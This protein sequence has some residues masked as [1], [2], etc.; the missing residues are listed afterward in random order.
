MPTFL[1]SKEF[2]LAMAGV[3]LFTAGWVVNGWR[4]EA[5]RTKAVVQAGWTG[6]HL[7]GA[8]NQSSMNYQDRLREDHD[9]QIKRARI[10][11]MAMAQAREELAGC[12]VDATLLR[13]LNDSARATSAGVSGGSVPT[14]APAEADPGGS[15]NCAAVIETYRWNAENVVRPNEVQLE[16]LTAFYKRVRSEYC[17]KTKVCV[18]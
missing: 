17:L 3:A 10:F 7:Q 15:S 16:E 8:A 1:L 4:H 11:A 2:W 12:R 18:P 13:V 5:A 9:H 6:Q 14:P